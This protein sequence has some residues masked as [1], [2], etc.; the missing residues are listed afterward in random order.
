MKLGL[1]HTQSQGAGAAVILDGHLCVNGVVVES[2][3]KY[4]KTHTACDVG[5]NE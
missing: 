4:I 1:H 5:P 3:H 2:S